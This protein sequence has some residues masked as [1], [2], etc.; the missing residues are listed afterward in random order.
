MWK[1]QPLLATG[2]GRQESQGGVD[3]SAW[4]GVNQHTSDAGLGID[5][6]SYVAATRGSQG[7]QPTSLP[8]A[9]RAP[10]HGLVNSFVN[11]HLSTL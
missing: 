10:S 7:E 11:H 6:E 3:A 9:G 2:Q 5:P 8:P 4:G 1:G